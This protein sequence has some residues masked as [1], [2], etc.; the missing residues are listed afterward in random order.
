MITK[1]FTSGSLRQ[2]RRRHK[3]VDIKAIKN[4]ARQI[5]QSLNYLHSQ[6]PPILPRDLKCDNIFVNGFKEIK[7]VGLGLATIMQKS[8]AQSVI[9]TLEFMA[10][11]LYEG[12]YNELIAVKK[13]IAKNS[14]SKY[15]D[16]DHDPLAQVFGKVKKGCVNFM[17]PDVTK[18]SIQST[19][20]LRAQI[21][22]GKKSYIDLEN[23][24][25][26]Y[27]AENDAKLDSLRDMVASLR[28]FE[29]AAT[30]T[31]YVDKS[32]VLPVIGFLTFLYAHKELKMI[33]ILGSV[34][35]YF[36]RCL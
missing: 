16:V 8:T 7:I 28:S 27:K 25:S 3:N 36:R 30:P 15:L 11:E 2:Y 31:V 22:E 6:K 32:Q 23:W 20:L 1:L 17:G 9:G 35:P 18:K 19:E 34:I 29:R 24:F 13:I 4:W 33:P 14:Q 5:L 26:Q 12:E 10:H 21:M